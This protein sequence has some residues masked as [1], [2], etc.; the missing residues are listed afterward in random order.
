MPYSFVFNTAKWPTDQ[1][2]VRK[3]INLAIDREKINIAAFLGERRP[4]YAT[5]SPATREFLPEAAELIYF[6]QGEA[7]ELL[8]A[9][10]F[11]DSDGDGILEQN[12]KPAVIDLYIFGAR[13]AN[14]SVIVA[15][16]IQA[17]LRAVGIDVNINV[18]PWD[19]QSVVAMHE[20]HHMINFDMPL[21]TASVLGVMFNSRETPREG[22]YGMGFTWFHKSNP[23]L[24]AKLD[25]LLDAG[26]N[27]PNLTERRDKFHAAQ[28]IIGE[29][30]L[31][32]PI[33]QGFTV[34]AMVKELKG[35]KYNDAGHA[36]FN[37]AHIERD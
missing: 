22:H 27:A 26:D 7:R 25:V 1:V 19:D 2:G 16:A 10:G 18:R 30:Y 17:D 32:V 29:N 6:A 23:D 34:Y 33:S 31:G 11:A 14:P 8:S 5:L 21:P 36:M 9:A 35:V 12:G 37:A 15:E 28:K 24:S 20:D 4:L 3:A 13:E